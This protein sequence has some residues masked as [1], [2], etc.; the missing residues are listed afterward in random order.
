MSHREYKYIP[1]F[2]GINTNLSPRLIEDNKL[3]TGTNVIFKNGKIK[4]RWGYSIT[5]TEADHPFQGDLLTPT[6]RPITGFGKY[7]RIMNPYIVLHAFTDTDVYYSN[8]GIYWMRCTTYVSSF[9]SGKLVACVGTK[10]VVATGDAFP[11]RW[12]AMQQGDRLLMKF[13]TTTPDGVG[14]PD[15]WYVVDS[16]GTKDNLSLLING[17]ITGGDVTWVVVEHFA[18][19]DEDAFW[20]RT[21]PTNSAT[22]EKVALYGN[23]KDPNLYT[24]D[25]VTFEILNADID[26]ILPGSGSP[27]LSSIWTTYYAHTIA[28]GGSTSG[29]GGNNNNQIFEN[30]DVGDPLDWST[31]EANAYLLEGTESRD[32]IMAAKELGGRLYFYKR[33]NITEVYYT[34]DSTDPFIITENKISNIG[35][36]N[37][38]TVAEVKGFHIFLG[39]DNVYAF[40]GN[41][42]VVIGDDII[43]DFYSTID[44]DLIHKSFAIVLSSEDLYILFAAKTGSDYP[45]AAWV[46]NYKEKHWVKWEFANTFT[47]GIWWKEDKIVLGDE[48]GQTY[49]MQ[50]EDDLGSYTT[51]DDDGTAIDVTL[52]TKDF[53]LND[54]KHVV[55][56]YEAVVGF[57]RQTAGQN[58]TLEASVDYGT[59]W[60]TAV[61]IDQG[62][63]AGSNTY[64]ENVVNLMQ[65]GKVIRFRIKNV[66][67]SEFEMESLGIGFVP[68]GK[69][70][71]G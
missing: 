41:S 46:L 6:A 2:R 23:G 52:E 64:M 68:A 59:T 53:V 51:D 20:G 15:T 40:N 33:H 48:A 11:V 8:S 19:G 10:S 45:N 39:E 42:P 29:L 16:L 14:D 57:T 9:T 50:T 3:V 60:S 34:G 27:R 49:L 5:P 67:G 58:I 36:I 44:I 56:I 28:A 17:P 31:G 24:S 12:G 66:S 25:G 63:P 54:P 62:L 38:R 65:H 70:I 22:E 71:T 21:Y 35:T 37:G 32:P 43:K 55:R 18:R 69:D 47:A 1:A 13:G 30:S 4:K 7:E 26:T 61:T